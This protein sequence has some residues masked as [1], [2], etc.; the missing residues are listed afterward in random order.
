[1][2]CISFDYSNSDDGECKYFF[3]FIA[4]VWTRT[5]ADGG[6]SPMYYPTQKRRIY[7]RSN[8]LNSVSLRRT[9]V[10]VEWID[11]PV[12]S[13]FLPANYPLKVVSHSSATLQTYSIKFGCSSNASVKFGP[14]YIFEKAFFF[15]GLFSYESCGIRKFRLPANKFWKENYLLDL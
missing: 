15:C 14:F 4:K 10:R 13:L 2:S 1:M 6:T 5:F 8:T 7:D 9:V 11:I 3:F 12:S